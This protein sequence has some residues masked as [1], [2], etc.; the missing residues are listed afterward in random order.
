MNYFKFEYIWLDGYKPV[1]NIRSKTR[2]MPMDSFDGDVTKLPKWSFD[3]SS[4]R[5][6]EGHF[7]DCSLMPKRVYVDPGREYAYFV[8]CEVNNPDGSPHPT[9]TRQSSMQKKRRIFG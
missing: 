4:T 7:S 9:N 2:I 8:I 3:G 1:A 5:Q 6:A